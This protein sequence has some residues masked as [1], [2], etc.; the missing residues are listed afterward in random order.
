MSFD[1]LRILLVCNLG[2][3]TGVMVAKMR[4]IAEASEKLKNKEVVIDARPAGDIKDYIEQYDCVLVG[5]QM[6]HK[7]DAIEAICISYKKP[8]AIIPTEVYGMADGGKIL[9]QALHLIVDN[10]KK[11]EGK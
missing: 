2:A 11:N 1:K 4:Q 9:K 7:Y 6:K 8:C 5:P 10:A 3:S